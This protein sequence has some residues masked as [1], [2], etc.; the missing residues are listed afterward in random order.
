V[1]R[2]LNEAGIPVK[3]FVRVLEGVSCEI[4]HGD[5]WRF[6]DVSKAAAHCTYIVPSA[7]STSVVP[8][9]F[10]FY[11]TVNVDATEM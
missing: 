1:V 9:V 6:E 10:D 7:S 3:A 4:F 11:K 8:H 2:E 5:I